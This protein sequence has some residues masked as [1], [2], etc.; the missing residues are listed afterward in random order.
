[1]LQGNESVAAANEVHGP[2]LQS[3]RGMDRR[4]GHAIGNGSELCRGS[5]VEVSD[6]G[7]EIWCCAFLRQFHQC[8]ERLP[9]LAHGTGGCRLL[10]RPAHRTEHVGDRGCHIRVSVLATTVRIRRPRRSP[11]SRDRLAHLGPVEVALGSTDGHR[12]AEFGERCFEFHLLS[13]DAIQH[14]DISRANAGIDAGLDALGDG[15]GFGDIVL[16]D[17]HVRGLAGVSS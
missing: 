14:G 6:K 2:P 16:E 4:Q 1:M 7:C 11:Q 12:N 9:L 13:V 15:L 17:L 10:R 8:R 5:L 3:L